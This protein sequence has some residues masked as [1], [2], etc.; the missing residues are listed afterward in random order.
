MKY[1]ETN[2]VSGS[3][4]HDLHDDLHKAA[5]VAESNIVFIL[6]HEADE[7]RCSHVSMCQSVYNVI[8]VCEAIIEAFP[9]DVSEKAL[10]NARSD[11]QRISERKNGIDILLNVLFGGRC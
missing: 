9:E 3:D 4:L 10:A 8:A 2:I 5:G 6:T 7:G 1:F 11:M